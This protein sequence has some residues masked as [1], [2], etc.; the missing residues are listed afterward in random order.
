MR[1]EGAHFVRARVAR[2]RGQ[3]VEGDILSSECVISHPW[4]PS[5]EQSK[6]VR[7]AQPTLTGVLDKWKNVHRGR[8]VALAGGV[9][10][11]GSQRVG[12]SELPAEAWTELKL[13]LS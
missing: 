4:T 8:E 11:H 10:V 12:Y 9:S 3:L 6:M 2:G 5:F 13:T 7:C 1:V